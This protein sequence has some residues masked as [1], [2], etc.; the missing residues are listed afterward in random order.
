MKP[1]LAGTL[2]TLDDLRFPAYC[3]PK[4]DGIRCLILHG[5]A[6]SRSLKPIPN[7]HIRDSLKD[8]P[9][10][11]DGELIL[12]TKRG[13]SEISSAVMSEDGEPDFVYCTF[14]YALYPRTP[15]LDRM[16]LLEKLEL[17]E[18]VIPVLPEKIDNIKEFVEYET[19]ML[20]AGAE[21]VMIR[22]EQGPYKY[23]RSTVRE[24]YLLKWKR[25]YDSDAEILGLVEQLRNDNVAKKNALGRTERSTC[26]D[27]KV[28]KGT[29]GAL[30]V[31]DIHSGQEFDVGTGFDAELRQT[32][33][34]NPDD[35]LGKI[36]KYKY[37][38]IGARNKPRFPVFLS[39][40]DEEDMDG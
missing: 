37:Q 17:P 7:K 16:E 6:M 38:E 32:I 33:W 28:G 24:G 31:K 20:A 23:G 26:K 30:K 12:R 2:T 1:M 11:L 19:R 15:Y 21:G 22:N 9:E 29:L 4:I 13:F 14:D 18:F 34:D 27:N 3:T 5:Q 8:L 35:Y 36:I 25:F 10:F 39:F 40:R